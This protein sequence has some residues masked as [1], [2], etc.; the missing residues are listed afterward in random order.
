MR[1]VALKNKVPN[2]EVQKVWKSQFGFAKELLESYSKEY[3]ATA[4]EEELKEIVINF[5]YLG[6]IH[7]AENLQQF[8]NKKNKL[9]GEN[10]ECTKKE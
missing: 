1:R 9:K 4:S 10:N 2:A 3:L 8:G 5:L 7:T 6:K